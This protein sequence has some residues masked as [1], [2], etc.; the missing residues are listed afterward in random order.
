MKN[1]LS[2]IVLVSGLLMMSTTIL[3]AQSSQISGNIK[4]DDGVPLVGVNI[5]V[6]GTILGTVTDIDGNFSFTVKESFPI[7]L[8]ISMIGYASQEFEATEANATSIDL[9][10]S[11]QALLGQEVVISASRMEQGILES[12]VSIEK[13]GILDIKNT[14]SDSYYKAIA[15]LKGVDMVT[16]SINFQIFNARGF[17]STSNTRF[18][19]LIDGMDTQAPALNFPIGSLNGPSDIDVE[20]VEFIPGA[21]SA[22]YG[23]NAFNGILLINSKNPFDYQGVSASVKLSVNHLGS[24]NLNSEDPISNPNQAEFGPGSAQPMYEANIR[25]AKAFNNKFAFKVN[26]TY[27]SATDWYGTSMQDRNEARTPAGFSY[28]P[29]ADRLHAFGDEVGINLGLLK[30]SSAFVAGAAGLGLDPDLL[31]N[32][33]VSRTPYLEEDIVDYNA[34][35]LKVGGGLYYRLTDKMELSYNYSYGGGTSIYTGAQ[36]YSL[37]NFSIQSHK[38]ELRA[39][40]F[41]VRGYTTIENSGDS[42]IAD[43]TGVLIN[44]QWKSNSAW[45]GA[46][47]IGYLNSIRSQPNEEIAH[48][49]A[50]AFADIGRFEPGTP[51]FEDALAT[52][53]GEVIPAGSLFADNSAMYH[54]EGQFNFKNQISFMD[55]LVG[56][57][58]RYYE[59]R[60]NGTIFPDTPGNPI[61]ISEYG[62]YA[63]GSKALLNDKLQLT[64]SV[65]FDKNENFNGQVNPRVSAVI[66][67][68]EG[69]NIRTSFQTGF[70]NP[71]T[72]GQHI[73]LNVVSARLIGGL[74]FYRERYNMYENAYTME[75]VDAFVQKFATEANGDGAQLGNPDYLD[76]LVPVTEADIPIVK[77]EQISSFELGYKSLINNKLMLDIVGYYNIYNDFI[78]QVRVRKASGAINI[79]QGT[80]QN[81]ADPNFWGYD[82]NTEQNIRNAQTLLTPI[83]TVGQENTFQTYTN[84]SETVTGA[85]A[86]IGADYIVGRGYTIGANYNWNRLIDGLGSN[87]LNEFNTPEH[88]ANVSFS[89]RKVTD[90]LGFNIT[91]RWQNAFFWG[92]T[93]GSGDVP[94]IGTMDAQ[95]SYRLDG[96]KSILKLGGSNLFNTRNVLSYGGPTLGS[97]YYLSLTFDELF[98]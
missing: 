74:P 84:T 77:P 55:L 43:L 9:S 35:N 92:S 26:F 46:Y 72:Q 33:A 51:E 44:D 86:A 8:K 71:T 28:N 70:R 42:Y 83:T 10:L 87:F 30:A 40:N 80:S 76:L 47:G 27:S 61:T 57:T 39:D 88:K 96:M 45:F 19:Q 2:R 14:A 78:A 68:A 34:K 5:I 81:P 3:W 31:P 4:G 50:R 21:A 85:G 53:T 48:N 95:V 52:A 15:N 97:I 98:N 20:S 1:L 6:L 62:A 32:I 93:F 24:S 67:V 38:V 65:R 16:S 17:N 79:P 18:V 73:D 58:F 56:A 36:R 91:Y 12:P 37:K 13:M 7:N 22:L 59:L 82:A 75:S 49:A 23:P 63:Q 41:F 64:A 29:G 94:A 60:S 66:K 69:H 11:E 25:Y 90:K 89:N 54:A